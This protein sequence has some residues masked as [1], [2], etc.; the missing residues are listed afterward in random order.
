MFYQ[1]KT[2]RTIALNTHYTILLSNPRVHQLT[3]LSVQVGSGKG[4]IEAY[5]H[6]TSNRG[7]LI[8][9]LSPQNSTP[10]KML[11]PTGCMSTYLTS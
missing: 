6:A 3:V 9:D 1:C 5:E 8:L 10:Y 7:Y 4:L 2:M 11:T